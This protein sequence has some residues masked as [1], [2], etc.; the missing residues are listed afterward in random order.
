[1]R[2]ISRFSSKSEGAAANHA[3]PLL[4]R[5]R[6]CGRLN[7]LEIELSLAFDKEHTVRGRIAARRVP[8]VAARLQEIRSGAEPEFRLALRSLAVSPGHDHDLHV[9]RVRVERSSESGRQ[10]E[11]RPE[12]ALRVIAPQIRN[13]DSGGAARVE[14]PPFQVA[15][16]YNDETACRSSR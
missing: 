7:Q 10:L 4:L 16:R 6:R 3:P 9:V 11:E 13:L 5:G 8:V 14:I 1:M 2:P 15:G 12:C